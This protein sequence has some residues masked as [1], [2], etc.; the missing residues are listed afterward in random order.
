M[1]FDLDLTFKII[2]K[3]AK[4]AKIDEKLASPYL[5]MT[6]LENDLE[7]VPNSALPFVET[8]NN[9][10]LDSE[11]ADFY[12]GDRYWRKGVDLIEGVARDAIVSHKTLANS[13][14]VEEFAREFSSLAEKFTA[15]WKERE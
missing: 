4:G 12:R 6:R 7:D 11:S 14:R 2:M 9:A 5:A 13:Q 8:N 15:K 10:D 1:T 3:I